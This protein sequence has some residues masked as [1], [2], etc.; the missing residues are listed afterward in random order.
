MVANFNPV[1]CSTRRLLTDLI[2]FPPRTRPFVE[3]AIFRFPNLS[4]LQCF[5]FPTQPSQ[6]LKTQLKFTPNKSQT[7][8]KCTPNNPPRTILI[9]HAI[10]LLLPC[11]IKGIIILNQFLWGKKSKTKSGEIVWND[12]L[13]VG[14]DDESLDGR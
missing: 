1:S 9:S 7:K 8:H 2:G 3:T 13:S 12:G 11:H 6:K 4:T 14:A 10:F 5:Y